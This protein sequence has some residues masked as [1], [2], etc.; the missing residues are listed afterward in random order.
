MPPVTDSSDYFF[1]ERYGGLA[2]IPSL[3][4][5]IR[6]E[7]E[8]AIQSVRAKGW[9]PESTPADFSQEL[10][11]YTDR[12]VSVGY[13]TGDVRF[14]FYKRVGGEIFW[15]SQRTQAPYIER[16]VQLYPDLDFDLVEQLWL[17]RG[18]GMPGALPSPSDPNRKWRS[19]SALTP[20]LTA[21]AA[22]GGPY[23]AAIVSPRCGIGGAEKTMREVAASLER[24]TGLP[25]LIVVA[26]T[27][28]DPADLPPGAIC[29][30][31]M[32]VRGGPFLRIPYPIRAM[33]LKDVLVEIG[34]PRVISMNSF[35][36]NTL[37]ETGALQTS[38]VKTASVLFC[39]GV[40]PG[41]AIEGY[42]RISDWLIDAG[43]VLFT[44]NDHIART[45]AERSFYHDTVVLAMPEAVT[46]NPAP[47]GRH[48]LWAGRIDTQ[49]R[50]ELLLEIAIRSPDIVYEVWGVPLLSDS[51]LMDAITNQPN[52]TYRGGFDSFDAIDM[53]DIACLLYTSAF[54]GTPNLLLEA[55]ARG[56]PCVCTAVGGIPDLMADG[57]GVLIGS[58]APVENYVAA[59][60][61]VLGDSSL[62][63]SI[64][65]RAREHIR[66]THSIEAFDKTVAR[67]LAAL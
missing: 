9:H 26:D 44:D 34:V 41:G 37:L 12:E 64:S 49:K 53:S 17:E 13:L 7:V 38:G 43:V 63:Q 42:I 51:A 2:L 1:R 15:R 33:V 18:R 54:D 58:D 66:L 27:V 61:D 19:M 40:G 25:S 14:P 23:A 59:L 22:A 11:F 24:L 67:L 30:P 31:N 56:L 50:P 55:M 32:M 46:S 39:A 21:Q 4:E 52:I 45:L 10:L 65:N 29:L 60:K 62:R 20:G 48:V 28:V 8:A 16:M 57:R 36:G 3:P 6:L 47:S 5:A 35:V